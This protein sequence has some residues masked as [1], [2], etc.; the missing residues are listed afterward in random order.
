MKSISGKIT[1]QA[2]GRDKPRPV[3]YSHP[4][5]TPC[6][7][8]VGT[9]ASVRPPD[10]PRPH[11]KPVI[12]KPVCALAVG[13][14]PSAASGRRIEVREWPRSKFPASAVRQRRNFGHR[15]RDI[16]SPVPSAPLPKG[17]WHGKAVTGGFSRRTA[18][19][20]TPRPVITPSEKIPTPEIESG[21]GIFILLSASFARPK[22]FAG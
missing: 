10:I 22:R 13:S 1:G 3:R 12:A 21:V 20:V 18:P 2:P 9:D 16:R 17:G 6:N 11:V 4:Y 7:A 8:S 14:E 19:L 5:R 15:N